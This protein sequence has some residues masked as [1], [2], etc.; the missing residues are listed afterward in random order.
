MDSRSSTHVG[1]NHY[2]DYPQVPGTTLPTYQTPTSSI[3]GQQRFINQAPLQS[4]LGQQGIQPQQQQPVQTEL[5]QE[6]YLFLKKWK[7]D[8]IVRRF[9]PIV[10]IAC[11]AQYY[12]NMTKQIPHSW[13]RYTTIVVT[14]YFAGI[15]SYRNEFKRRV[16][17][18]SSNTP[19][20][21]KARAALGLTG[22]IPPGN[23]SWS[24]LD[25]YETPMNAGPNA[26]VGL[27]SADAY[28]VNPPL[29]AG[30]GNM[31]LGYKEDLSADW[32]NDNTVNSPMSPYA[33]P[34]PVAPSN[35]EHFNPLPAEPIHRGNAVDNQ[36]SSGLTYDE[37]RAR[38]RGMLR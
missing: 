20:M 31:G 9:L 35:M 13:F 7:N 22:V 36:S 32:T 3:Y 12:Y 29:A 8:C 14:S 34:S 15:V 11:G 26:A 25:G 17:A 37:I 6:D 2:G 24:T 38:N 18:S 33:T 16:A 5:T 4:G 10:S 27:Y 1:Q 19:F 23:S 30:D 21:M 28:S